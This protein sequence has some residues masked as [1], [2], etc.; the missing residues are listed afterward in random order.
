MRAVWALVLH[1]YLKTSRPCFAY[2]VYGRDIT[3]SNEDVDAL[4]IAGPL[5]NFL[6][7]GAG[8]S[9]SGPSGGEIKPEMPVVAF[10]K[11]V[12][13]DYLEGSSYQDFSYAEARRGTDKIV[14]DGEGEGQSEVEKRR[15]RAVLFNTMVNFRRAGTNEKQRDFASSDK[16]NEGNAVQKT[17]ELVFEEIGCRDPMEVSPYLHFL[18]PSPGPGLS[19]GIH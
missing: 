8:G 19:E 10:L 5:F 2:T 12:Q 7:Y 13:D 17:G 18:L 16:E 11:Q 1:S 15:S 4:K 14:R 6:I 3:L 9:D